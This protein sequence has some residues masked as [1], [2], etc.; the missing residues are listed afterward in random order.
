[1][2]SDV[3]LKILARLKSGPVE[4][5]NGTLHIEGVDPEQVHQTLVLMN[6]RNEIGVHGASNGNSDFGADPEI[7]FRKI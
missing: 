2:S 3:R 5:E 7:F 1:M 6:D 4:A